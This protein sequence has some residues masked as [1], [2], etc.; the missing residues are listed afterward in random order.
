[1]DLEALQKIPLVDAYRRANVFPEM[2]DLH[3]TRD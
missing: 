3:L 1:M 2:T